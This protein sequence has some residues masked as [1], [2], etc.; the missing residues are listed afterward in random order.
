MAYSSE[1]FIYSWPAD[2]DMSSVATNQYSAVAIGPAKN[3]QG[4]GQG[5]CAVVAYK[6]GA[7]FI[8]ILLNAPKQGN[9]ASLCLTGIT[10]CRAAGTWDAGD[11]LKVVEGGMLDKAG[12]GDKVFGRAGESAVPG[13]I[14]TVIL[15]K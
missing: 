3:V 4:A 1:R 14:S 15:L 11:K 8:G 10:R 5:N 12:D 13:D 2:V 6:E 7:D 9:G